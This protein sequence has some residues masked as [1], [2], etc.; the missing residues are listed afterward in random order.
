RVHYGRPRRRREARSRQRELATIVDQVV[1][2][3]AREGGEAVHGRGSVPDDVPDLDTAYEERIG[4][5]LTMATP[6]HRFGAEDGGRSLARELEQPVE[7]GLELVRVHVVGVG[8]EGGALPG[9]VARVALPAASPA[10]AGK[11]GVGD[12]RRRERVAQ[13]LAREVR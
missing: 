11:P 3:H 1:V 8:A 13:R 2:D 6:G 7:R 4:D 10:Q 5:Q 12:A 9:D